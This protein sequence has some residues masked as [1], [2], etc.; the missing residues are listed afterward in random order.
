[1]KRRLLS[2]LLCGIM[3]FSLCAPSVSA[4][5]QIQDGGQATEA[6]GLGG[7]HAEDGPDIGHAEGDSG[8]P[9]THEHTGDCYTSVTKCVHV[10]DETCRPKNGE[11]EEK[12]SGDEVSEGNAVQA[13]GEAG[14]TEGC[15]HVC[16][17]ESGCITEE[18]SCRHEHDGECGYSPA[19]E[20]NDYGFVGNGCPAPGNGPEQTEVQC[21]CASPCT[22]ENID[23]DCPVCG[24]EGADLALCGGGKNNAPCG[25]RRAEPNVR[26]SPGGKSESEIGRAHV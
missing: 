26:A 16:S 24:A 7:D 15:P 5:G 22:E 18:L 4:E 19:M 11:A 14:E 12:A 21:I 2:L 6:D 23:R 1:M 8:T 13:G 9:C 20:G 10:H 25:C 17:G 3:L